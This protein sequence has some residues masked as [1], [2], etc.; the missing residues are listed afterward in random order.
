M[1]Y[2]SLLILFFIDTIEFNNSFLLYYNALHIFG[3]NEYF[4]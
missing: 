1:L 4:L 3:G 2:F